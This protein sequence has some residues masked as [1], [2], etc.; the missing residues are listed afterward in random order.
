MN[1]LEGHS[2]TLTNLE[3]CFCCLKT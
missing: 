2:M 3:G 1:D